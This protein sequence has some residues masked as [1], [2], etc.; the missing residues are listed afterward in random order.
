MRI[1][2]QAAP[3]LIGHQKAQKA[4]GERRRRFLEEYSKVRDAQDKVIAAS[5]KKIQN[6]VNVWMSSQQYGNSRN[7]N[8]KKPT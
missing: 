8:R 5:S 7:G 2:N 1:D 4:F 3:F 6:K